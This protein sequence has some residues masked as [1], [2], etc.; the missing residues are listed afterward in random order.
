MS[1]K[2]ESYLGGLTVGSH[3]PGGDLLA[4]SALPQGE[5]GT[6]RLVA[7]VQGDPELAEG[8]SWPS[9]PPGQARSG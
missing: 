8:G 5:K 7:W 6:V 1:T 9:R 3:P 4:N 2:G